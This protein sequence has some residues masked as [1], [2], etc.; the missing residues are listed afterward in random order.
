M[1]IYLDAPVPHEDAIDYLKGKVVLGKSIFDKLPPSLRA[2]A[3]TVSGIDNFAVLRDIRDKCAAIPQGAS[4]EETRQDI[5]NDLLPY[6]SGD[7]D[8]DDFLNDFLPPDDKAMS[9]ARNRAE[10][11]MRMNVG[12]SYAAAYSQ[13][14]DDNQD[15]FPYRQYLTMGDGQ[16]RSS[17]AA[18]NNLI[19]P[20]NHPFW[21]THTPPWEFGCRCSFAGIMADEA[22]GIAQDE[23]DR[24]TP[25]EQRTV[26]DESTLE[27]MGK[28]GKLMRGNEAVD[29]RTQHQRQGK[30]YQWNPRELNLTRSQTLEKIATDDRAAFENWA[31]KTII[32]ELGISVWEWMS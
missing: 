11:V 1:S 25:P 31:K 13:A 22:E 2:R 8:E 24:G 7:D 16:V 17:H 32:P 18:L 4:W 27:A 29:I 5:A 23:A 26:L 15:V 10:L 14:L 30:G 9:K 28:T 12:Q 20:A 21:D 3:T 6:F 19:L